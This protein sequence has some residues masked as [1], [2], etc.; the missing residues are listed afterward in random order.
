MHKPTNLAIAAALTGAGL[1]VSAMAQDAASAAPETQVV[2]RDDA[3]QP[4]KVQIGEQVYDVCTPEQQDGC[5]NPRSA[6]LDFGTRELNYWPGKPASEIEEDL[7]WEPAEQTV[8]EPV[9]E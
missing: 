2:E 8:E 3:G 5:I 4:T 1:S 7:P 6:G 9:G